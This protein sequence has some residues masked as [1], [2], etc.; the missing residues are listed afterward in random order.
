[1][2]F[3]TEFHFKSRLIEKQLHTHFPHPQTLSEKLNHVNLVPTLYLT[4]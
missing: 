1:M 2:H 4:R 3:Q